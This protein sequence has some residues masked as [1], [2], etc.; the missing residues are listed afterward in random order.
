MHTGKKVICS[1]MPEQMGAYGAAIFACDWNKQNG[2]ETKFSGLE[3][4]ESIDK[5]YY[6]KYSMQRMRK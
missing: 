5:V 3:N 4:L 2:S 1:D 6:Q